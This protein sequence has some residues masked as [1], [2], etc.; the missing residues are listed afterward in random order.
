VIAAFDDENYLG[1]FGGSPMQAIL[2]TGDTQLAEGTRASIF[3]WRPLVDAKALI[4][5]TATKEAPG[6]DLRW[7]DP[8][9][10]NRL[11][12]IP[13]QT[14]GLYHRFEL[15]IPPQNWTEVHGVYPVDGQP[16]GEQ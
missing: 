15:T 2:Q 13:Q 11:G 6:S 12:I 10:N 4:G 8:V 5:R 16:D 9:D 7:R 14:S 1:F 3:G